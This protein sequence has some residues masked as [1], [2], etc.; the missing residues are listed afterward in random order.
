MLKEV[1]VFICY[2]I[3][4]GIITVKSGDDIDDKI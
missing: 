1:L 2:L 4:V 3:V